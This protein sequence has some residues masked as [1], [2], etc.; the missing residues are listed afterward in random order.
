MSMAPLNTTD[1]NVT[2]HTV[3]DTISNYKQCNLS[4]S[5]QKNLG[6]LLNLS[7]AL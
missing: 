4:A 6:D 5:L 3:V 7:G 2:N 1:Q